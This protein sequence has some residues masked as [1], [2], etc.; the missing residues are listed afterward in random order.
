MGATLQKVSEP[1]LITDMAGA[2]M[3]ATTDT[4]DATLQKV[5]EPALITDMAGATMSATTDTVDVI[6][7]MVAEMDLTI[8]KVD[9]QMATSCGKVDEK[10]LVDMADLTEKMDKIAELRE[11]L[12]G[13]EMY[14]ERYAK[15]KEKILQFSLDN[16][17]IEKCLPTLSEKQK[18]ARFVL[19]KHGIALQGSK[20][21]DEL[22]CLNKSGLL[23]YIRDTYRMPNYSEVPNDFVLEDN[24]IRR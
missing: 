22:R 24:I 3:G 18:K 6:R 14:I 4:T 5:S 8:S 7:Q 23:K 21:H 1:A 12:H 20:F 13:A 2:T 19:P 15:H 11:L 10:L 16:R 9:Q 17:F